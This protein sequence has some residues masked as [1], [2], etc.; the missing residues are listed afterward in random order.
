VFP[1]T[2]FDDRLAFLAYHPLLTY[3]TDP[4]L[5]SMFRRSL[6]RSGEI[7]RLD[8]MV[9]FNYIYGALTGNDMD[10]ERSLKNLREWP[11]DCHSYTCV[12][13]HRADLTVPE[14]YVNYIS[15]KKCMSGRSIGPTRW[16]DDFMRLDG[17]G[18]GASISD[19]SAFLD[20]YW[21]A[22]YYGMILPPDIKDDRLLTVEKRGLQ[23]GA[24]PYDGPPRPDVG[25]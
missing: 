9:W 20:A 1:A 11:L 15:D 22:R 7:K 18:G 25:F 3:E 10:N 6:E 16:D 13:S 12:N 5:R 23:F 19:P 8:N 4:Q 21:M 17:G 14:G 24:E 2:H